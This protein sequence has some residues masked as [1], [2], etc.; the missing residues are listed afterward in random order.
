[1]EELEYIVGQFLDKMIKSAL[2]IFTIL[3]TVSAEVTVL[4]NDNFAT[5]LDNNEYVLVKFYAPWCG[6]CKKLAPHYD[7]LSNEG[8]SDV[9]IAKVDATVETAL[10]K[11]HDVKGYPTLKWFINGTEYDFKGGRDFDTMNAFLKKAT[12]E[13]AAFI[14]NGKELESFLEFGDEDAVVVSNNDASYLRP[15]ASKLGALNFAH[16]TGEGLLPENT[17]RIYNKFDGSLDFYDYVE[18]EGG[19]S[20]IN[21]LRKHS[22]PF[23]NK[24]DSTAIKRGFE[25]SR[26]HFIVFA[27]DDQ[28]E[29]VVKIIRP[30]A[31]EY[32]PKY[33]FVTV[34]HNNK[35]VVDMFGVTTFPSAVLVNLSPKIVKYPMDGTVTTEKLRGHL[36]A[37]ERG[38]L[39]PV[40]KSEDEPDQEDGTP[41]KL[42]GKTFDNFVSANKNVFV[43]F[44]AP[45][46]GHCKK[47]APTW[48]EL[49]EKLKD[50]DVVIAKYD[51]TANENEQVDVK[52]FPTLKYYKD[53]N[54]IDYRGGR[55]L[56]SLIKFI[57]EQNP[58]QGSH[59]EL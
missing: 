7:R 44:Y 4:N 57:H 35:Q 49:A 55:D 16:V 23:V 50:E 24:L 47:L 2:L 38:D 28:R 40:L 21:F 39:K 45:W 17:L 27:E 46:C 54:A 36:E 18:E 8:P 34:K 19:P 59:T 26:Q 43:K 20:D 15:L 48:D 52:G 30:V 29:D 51:A 11:E 31:E 3:F 22:I 33:I 42:V 53:G 14:K 37:F 12:G 32:S 56:D 58:L 10:A 6:H 1:V 25:Y 5:H 9:S 13:W 41:Y